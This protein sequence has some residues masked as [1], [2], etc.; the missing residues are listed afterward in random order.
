MNAQIDMFAKGW[1]DPIS[2]A[3]TDFFCKLQKGAEINCPICDRYSHFNRFKINRS[4]VRAMAHLRR[5]QLQMPSGYVHHTKFLAGLSRGF[6]DLK[7]WNMIEPQIL[8]IGES[9]K[10]T[11][12][13]WRVNQHGVDF[14]LGKISVPKY[15]FVF[16]DCTRGYSEDTITVHDAVGEYFYY[17]ETLSGQLDILV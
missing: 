9:Q 6:Y 1:N 4:M 7:R 11:S 14:L 10:R 17:Q 13:Y 16:D 15:A 3:R 5:L 2:E 8:D 12:G